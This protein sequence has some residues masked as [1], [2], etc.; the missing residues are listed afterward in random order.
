MKRILLVGYDPVTVDFSDPALPPGMTPETIHAGTAMSLRIIAERGWRGSIASSD[1]TKPLCRDAFN[2]F[3]RPYF[4]RGAY[5]TPHGWSSYELTGHDSR[6]NLLQTE[7][8][9]ARQWGPS[10]MAAGSPPRQRTMTSRGQADETRPSSNSCRHSDASSLCELPAESRN[11]QY[12]IRV[13]GICG[14]RRCVG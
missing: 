13:I 7:G 9:P 2:H 5:V 8:S 14:V 1:P 12:R 3:A 11:R 10:M 4:S 6:P